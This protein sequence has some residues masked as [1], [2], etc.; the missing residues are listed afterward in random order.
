MVG[1]ILGA[2]A[3][4]TIAYAI[5]AVSFVVSIVLIVR[6]PSRLLQSER[7]LTRGY[8][9]DLVDGFIVTLRSRSMVAVLV[10]WGIASFG[11]GAA[12]VSQIFL[13]K[14]TF[15][16]GRLGYGFLSGAIGAGLVLGAFFSAQVLE[17]WGVAVSYGAGLTVMGLGLVSAALSPNIWIAG[18]CCVVLGVGNGLAV[19]C[20]A[21]LV[22]R[23][24][25]D[26]MRGRAL[27]FVMSATYLAVAVGEFA[28]GAFVHEGAASDVP[29][30]LWGIAGVLLGIAAVAGWAI[31]RRLG[32]ETAA[33]GEHAPS[34]VATAN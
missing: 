8:W 1:P 16:S 33:E 29:R 22:Q 31:A 25:F 21:L 28:G 6:I 17:R 34:A 7:A 19:G 12:N 32:S 11:L 2:A 13:A 23:G 24:T 10:A 4:P 5:N 9:R 15:S 30:W 27:T 20:N 14:H 18:A 26:M 3:G